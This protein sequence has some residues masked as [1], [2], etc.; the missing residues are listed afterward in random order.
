M[1]KQM[2]PGLRMTILLTVLT[3]LLYPGLVTAICQ[4]LF[5]VAAN[6]SLIMR[7]GKIIGSVLIGQNFSR[8]EYFHPRPSA[9][10]NDGYDASSS[11]GSN[12]GPTSRKLI[13]RVKAAAEKLRA[14]ETVSGAIP[15][16][17]LTT[18]ASGLDPH[19]SP[20]SAHLQIARVAKVRGMAEADLAK[21]VDQFT[22]GRDL[23]FLGEPRVNVL[24]LNLA[25][26][27]RQAVSK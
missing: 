9:A 8:P 13:D 15:S 23:G 17:L 7:N 16:D 26:N 19:I 24:L 18:S 20:A 10:G 11:G 27:D 12:L 14:G 21:L 22:T 6:G 1:W 2:L 5:P 25:L 4:S 3:G